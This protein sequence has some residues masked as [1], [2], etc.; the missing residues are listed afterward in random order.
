[1]KLFMIT[2]LG[3]AESLVS[4]KQGAFYY[5]LQEFHK[6]WDRIDIIAPRTNNIKEKTEVF[7]E[8]VYV[9]S[10]GWPLVMHPIFFLKKGFELWKQE[11]FDLM[12]VH[13]FPPFYNGV[14]A[15]ILRWLTGV[16]YILEIMHIPGLPR[17]AGVRETVYKWLTKLFVALDAMPARAV[18]IIN[19]Q[20][21]QFLVASGIPGS[22]ILYIPAF[23]ID[24]NVFCPMSV[25]KKYDL[26]FAGRL[27]KNKRITNLIKAVKILRKEKPDVSLLII[28]S[29]PLRSELQ[30]LIKIEGLE[31]NITFS[32]WLESNHDIA[33]AYQSAKIFV[34]PSLNEGGPRVVLEAMAC[35]LPILTTKVGLMLDIIIEGETGLFIDWSPGDIAD[36]VSRVLADADLR[37]RLSASGLNIVKQFER[38]RAIKNYAESIQ[39]LL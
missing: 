32:G 24:L 1:M 5:T 21:K 16:P 10:S 6:H 3:S 2:G 15:C 28:G 8:N 26:V 34:N 39:R 13:E 35:G 12:T 22:K 9:H 30:T 29:G 23:Y 19:Q 37:S 7:F 20:T 25:D 11:K 17:A 33:K 38:S 4:G 18:R 27:E 31:E 36:K 14:G